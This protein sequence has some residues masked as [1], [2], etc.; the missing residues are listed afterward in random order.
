MS[1]LDTVYSLDL[2][3]YTSFGF[4]LHMFSW[5][6][7]I[8]IWT[9]LNNSINFCVSTLISYYWFLNAAITIFLA[10]IINLYVIGPF[11]NDIKINLMESVIFET[12]L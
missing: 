10:I 7:T 6:Y 1:C 9:V 2:K 5:F 11:L 8:R 3:V 4:L 12:S